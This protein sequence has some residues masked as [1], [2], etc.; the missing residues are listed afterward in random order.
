MGSTKSYEIW[1][2]RRVRPRIPRCECTLGLVSPVRGRIIVCSSGTSE[3]NRLCFVHFQ[4]LIQVEW[5]KGSYSQRRHERQVDTIVQ[6][7][8]TQGAGRH[9]S[10]RRWKE[11]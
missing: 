5:E 4:S 9:R 8:E 7:K 3:S 6:S 1:R 11:V 10:P 2:R